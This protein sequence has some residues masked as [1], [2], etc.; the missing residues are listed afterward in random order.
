VLHATFVMPDGKTMRTETLR[1]AR[2]AG[3]DPS[4]LYSNAAVQGSLSRS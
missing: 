2:R 4:D 1:Y 3:L